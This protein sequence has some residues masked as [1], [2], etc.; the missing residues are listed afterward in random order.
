VPV[1]GSHAAAPTV[2]G[3]RCGSRTCSAPATCSW[4]GTVER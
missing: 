1:R 4:R 3:A 2:V